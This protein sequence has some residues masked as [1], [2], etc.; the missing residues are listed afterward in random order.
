MPKPISK[1]QTEIGRSTIITKL[2]AIKRNS[3]LVEVGR[4]R[5]RIKL[6]K[7]KFLRKS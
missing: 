3:D 4:I 1:G 2:G 7:H 6:G 5:S